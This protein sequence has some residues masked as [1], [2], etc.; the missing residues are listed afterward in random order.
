MSDIRG[1][2]SSS[3]KVVRTVE[4]SV[5]HERIYCMLDNKPVINLRKHLLMHYNM[6][7]D[8]YLAFCGLPDDYPAVPER[9]RQ[10]KEQASQ[11]MA[12]LG[13]EEIQSPPMIVWAR[14][15]R[16]RSNEKGVH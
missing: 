4:G 8:D 14:R 11:K 1:K 9:T 6:S 13:I 16:R 5:T 3:L 15:T 12:E 2:Y 10:L 7:F